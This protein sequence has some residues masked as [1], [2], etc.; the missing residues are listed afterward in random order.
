MSVTD[1]E[2]HFTVEFLCD[3]SKLSY[4]NQ[5]EGLTF[6]FNNGKISATTTSTSI[7][8]TNHQID[9]LYDGTRVK[10]VGFNQGICCDCN[11]LSLTDE[12][13]NPLPPNS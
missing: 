9:F 8:H 11:V 13:G 2:N 6:A 5:W 12:S 1:T 10:Q 7:V 3:K 4:R